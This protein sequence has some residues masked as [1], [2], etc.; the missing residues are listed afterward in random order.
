[1]KAISQTTFGFYLR[2]Q[3]SG[4]VPSVDFH[5]NEVGVRTTIKF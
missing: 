3:N 2:R 5:S 1:L 4:S